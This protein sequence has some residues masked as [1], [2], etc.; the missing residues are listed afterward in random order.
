[1]GALIEGLIGPLE[2]DAPN[3]GAAREAVQALTLLALRAVGIVDARAR[4][5]VVQVAIPVPDET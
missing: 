2:A 5:L 1:M 3:K 4:G